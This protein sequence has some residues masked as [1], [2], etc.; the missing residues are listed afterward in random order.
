MGRQSGT[1]GDI[2]GNLGLL[3]AELDTGES[4]LTEM[5]CRERQRLWF[6][7]GVVVFLLVTLG[8]TGCVARGRSR[9]RG[10]LLNGAPSTF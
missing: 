5:R 1:I 10:R 7:R 6:L 3:D 9:T 2:S 8:L 4:L